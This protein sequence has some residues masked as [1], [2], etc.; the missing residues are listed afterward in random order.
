ME[1]SHFAGRL[2]E[3][4]ERSGVSQ[5]D[6]AEKTGLTIRQVSRLETG[7]QKPTWET[8]LALAAALN[9][10]CRAFAEP[11]A[12]ERQESRRGRPRKPAAPSADEPTTT[13]KPRRRKG[14]SR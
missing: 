10:D 3:L 4:R 1:A 6:I 8:V 2:K 7:A 9:V 13:E 11:P 14:G 12:T 5:K